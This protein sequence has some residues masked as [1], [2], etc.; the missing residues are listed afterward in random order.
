MSHKITD[1]EL[2]EALSDKLHLSEAI[3]GGFLKAYFEVICEGLEE[4]GLVKISGLG[5]FKLQKTESRRIVNIQTGNEQILPAHFKVNFSP[6]KD[7]ASRLNEPFS[8][9]NTIDLDEEEL[10]EEPIEPIAAAAREYFDEEIH[11]IPLPIDV[12]TT[13]MH[14]ESSISYAAGNHEEYVTDM[15]QAE[16]DKTVIQSDFTQAS[17]G[18][19][20]KSVYYHSKEHKGY[21]V[22]SVL[23]LLVAIGLFVL[24]YVRISSLKSKRNPSKVIISENVI[25]TRSS[26]T[27]SIS[28]GLQK[29][30]LEIGEEIIASQLHTDPIVYEP[31]AK[32]AIRY[33]SRLTLLAQKY[34]GNKHFWCYIFEENKSKIQNPNQIPIGTLL[35]IPDPRKYEISAQ[36]AE[37]VAK[38]KQYTDDLNSLYK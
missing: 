17:P 35:D 34:Y 20:E 18:G 3:T 5:T 8:H 7:L 15:I 4:D 33:G 23:L 38:A 9:L 19:C 2:I 31:I 37:S 13:H 21:M 30:S 25:P 6:D 12:D 14:V 1:K 32:E 26:D 11:E 16:D 24:F 27:D 29:D 22:A 36:S 10:K 28:P